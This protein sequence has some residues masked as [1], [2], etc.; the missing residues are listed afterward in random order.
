[1]LQLIMRWGAIMAALIAAVVVAAA[2][3]AAVETGNC[4]RAA[5]GVVAAGVGYCLAASYVELIRLI[6]DMLLPK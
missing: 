2:I 5:A 4:L 1:M 6:T 3:W